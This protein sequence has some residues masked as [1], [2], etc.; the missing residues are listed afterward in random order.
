MP[1]SCYQNTDG[2][3]GHVSNSTCNE[4]EL[5]EYGNLGS[6]TTRRGRLS[7]M[8]VAL[9]RPRFTSLFVQEGLQEV[10]ILLQLRHELKEWRSRSREEMALVLK[11][12]HVE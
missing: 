6:V 1:S 4:A 5:G 8:L 9:I 7:K 11:N 12:C 2:C 3:S 10:N